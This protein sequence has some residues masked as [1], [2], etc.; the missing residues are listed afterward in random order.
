[1]WELGNGTRGELPVEYNTFTAGVGP[2]GLRTKNDIRVLLCYLLASV[3][4]PLKQEDILA[5][6]QEYDLA[7]YFEVMDA[8]SD[9]LEKGLIVRQKDAVTVTKEGR[10]IAAQL[11]VTLPLSV[12][13]K[14]VAAAVNLLARAKREQENRVEIKKNEKGYTVTC[15]VSD[16]EMDLMTF[17][18]Y[19]PDLYQARLIKKNFHR[20]PETVYRILLAAVTGS[21][22]LAADALRH[23][24][25]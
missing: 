17:S 21:R 23:I 10:E 22:D 14:T 2:G 9:L 12:R 15:H 24:T 7:N 6:L 20:N 4:A 3:S 13:E 8:I 11:D 25:A 16:G 5:I 18:L 19:A 1:M